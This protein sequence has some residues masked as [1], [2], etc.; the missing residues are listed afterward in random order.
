MFWF[1]PEQEFSEVLSLGKFDEN[2]QLSKE[3][4]LKKCFC[5]GQAWRGCK[6]YC[7]P[8]VSAWGSH[9]K[10]LQQGE[11]F[12]WQTT[13]IA[14]GTQV[15]ELC[16]AGGEGTRGSPETG[17]RQWVE[18]SSG[19]RRAVGTTVGT[20]SVEESSGYHCRSSPMLSLIPGALAHPRCPLA[21][22]VP[23]RIPA[24]CGCGPAP[25]LPEHLPLAG[26]QV[27]SSGTDRAVPPRQPLTAGHVFL[28]AAKTRNKAGF[29]SLCFP[30][31]SGLPWW[32]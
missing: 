3:K 6:Y 15:R 12:S 24:R 9:H 32:L 28:M 31:V 27:P 1:L 16:D 5:W 22:P 13:H 10:K 23:S 11:N 30:S 8:E 25:V 14:G 7:T 2:R 4:G 29:F 21:S 20:T 17:K 19:W 18:E 26:A